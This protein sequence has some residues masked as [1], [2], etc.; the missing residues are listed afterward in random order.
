MRQRIKFS[1]RLS[2]KQLIS[3]HG[4][5]ARQAVVY[6]VAMAWEIDF[7]AGSAKI[8]GRE[9]HGMVFAHEPERKVYM[10][11]AIPD[12]ITFAPNAGPPQVDHF[13]IPESDFKLIA[14]G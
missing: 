10:F 3:R 5:S 4:T 6:A 12:R 11:A 2:L 13:E 1:L 8:N 14:F 7:K 9:R